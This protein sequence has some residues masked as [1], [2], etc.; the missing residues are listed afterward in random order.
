MTLSYNDYSIFELKKIVVDKKS[1]CKIPK[2]F[3]AGLS[4]LMKKCWQYE[5]NNRPD[6][7]EILSDKWLPKIKEKC[8]SKK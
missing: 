2:I 6:F 7:E 4:D 3:S 1:K 8:N 5:P